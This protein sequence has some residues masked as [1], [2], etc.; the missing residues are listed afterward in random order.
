MSN[1]RYTNII[2]YNVYGYGMKLYCKITEYGIDTPNYK[3]SMAFGTGFKKFCVVAAYDC[4]KPYEIYIDRVEKKDKCTINNSLSSFLEGSVNFVKVSLWAMTKL[5]PH[6][7]KYTFKDDSQIY[8]DG[9]NSKDTMHL[10]FDYILKYNETWYQ[11]KFGAELPGF[12]SKHKNKNTGLIVIKSDKNSLMKSVYD[13]FK[14]LDEELVPIELVSDLIPYILDYKQEYNMSK[15]P[16]EFINK[17]R[18]KL[19]NKY[20]NNVGKW[21]NNYMLYLKIDIEM[22]KWYIPKESIIQPSEFSM[23]RM[24]DENVKHKLNG[25]RR[26]TRKNQR[27]KGYSIVS[28]YNLMN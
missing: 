22:G 12:I 28:K 11:S 7:E 21:L 27:I 18:K 25:G 23:I 2:G 10:G 6:V 4:K 13:S 19:G 24:S 14:S 1:I 26:E 15:T 5:Y 9:E 8:C 16:R 20:C 3:C 17:L